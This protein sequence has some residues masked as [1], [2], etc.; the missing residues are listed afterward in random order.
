LQ[1][2]TARLRA[3]R[4]WETSLTSSSWTCKGNHQ[5]KKT[6]LPKLSKKFLTAW[7]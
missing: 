2:A 4:D 3:M 5:Q 7:V 1:Q 6:W